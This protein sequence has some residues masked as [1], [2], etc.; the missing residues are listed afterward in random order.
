MAIHADP[1]GPAQDRLLCSACVS[2]FDR[3][4]GENQ[5][6]RPMRHVG[7]LDCSR[8]PKRAV[9][10]LAVCLRRLLRSRSRPAFNCAGG[11]GPGRCPGGERKRLPG[12]SASSRIV[13]AR[14]AWKQVFDHRPVA[15][16]YRATH[17]RA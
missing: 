13:A 17:K 8:S 3:G 5:T 2:E 6:V 14:G 15:L 9:G 1:L 7:A 4:L 10:R 12:E 16:A 11:R